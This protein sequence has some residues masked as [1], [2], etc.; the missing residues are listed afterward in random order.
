M[1]SD[2]KS[3]KKIINTS[4]A[5]AAAVSDFIYV[6]FFSLGFLINSSDSINVQRPDHFITVKTFLEASSLSFLFLLSDCSN[7]N[8]V[9]GRL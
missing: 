2:V 3:V 1:K 9:M 8:K 4:S 7:T 6:K 5:S